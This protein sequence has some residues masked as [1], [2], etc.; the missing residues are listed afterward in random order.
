MNVIA[1]PGTKCPMEGKPREYIMDAAGTDV[2]ETT[3]YQR[4]IL[5]GSLVPV[6]E[7]P[8]KAK[9]ADKTKQGGEEA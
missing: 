5:D 1:A 4:L 7:T 2:P 9:K 8:P 6:P 3:Y